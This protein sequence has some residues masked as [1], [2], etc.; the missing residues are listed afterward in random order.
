LITKEAL[1]PDYA[2]LKEQ[3]SYSPITPQLRERINAE[4]NPIVTDDFNLRVFAH[5]L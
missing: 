2:H 3:L 4:N 5:L 1:H